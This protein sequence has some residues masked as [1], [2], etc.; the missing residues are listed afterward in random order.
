MTPHQPALRRLAEGLRDLL[1]PP[2]CV[3]CN[4]LL[5]PFEREAAVL[6][7]ICRAAWDKARS[8]AAA[9]SAEAAL[10][11]HAYLILYRSGKT[12]GV[13]ERLIYHLKHQ[14]DPRA[15]AFVA[16]QLSFAVHM[17]ATE[18]GH[19]GAPLF[20]YP[21]RR[22]ASV[23]KDGFDQA[24]RLAKALAFACGGEPVSLLRRTHAPAEEQKTLNTEARRENA[25]ASYALRRK[26]AHCVRGRTVVL[27]DDLCTTGATLAACEALLME[28]GA[29][30]VVWATVGQTK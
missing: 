12:D 14:G 27:C 11:G 17:A 19:A 4:E 16:G 28:A 6:C 2:R 7:P 1:L 30:A 8:D 9:L 10:R 24:E 22:R 23:G 25:A 15:F 20:T 18:A 13:P 21:P 5:P 3:G 29:A 26:I